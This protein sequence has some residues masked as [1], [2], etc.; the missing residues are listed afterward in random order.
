MAR[1][2]HV[3]AWEDEPSDE[4]PSEFARSTGY[5]GLFSTQNGQLYPSQIS[6]F[7]ATRSGADT[8]VDSDFTR[9]SPLP[10]E[11]VRTRRPLREVP[12]IIVLATILGGAAYLI[13]EFARIVQ[14]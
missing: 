5:G 11:R 9:P 2:Y 1:D 12:V 13:V 10:R 8:L 6:A 4:R 14:R 3:F 7:S